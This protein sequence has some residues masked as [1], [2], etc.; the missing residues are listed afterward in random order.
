MGVSVHLMAPARWAPHSLKQAVPIAAVRLTVASED[1]AYEWDLCA[2]P[3]LLIRNESVP[4]ALKP[5]AAPDEPWPVAKWPVPLVPPAARALPVGGRVRSLVVAHPQKPSVRAYKGLFKAVGPLFGPL[6]CAH[7][8]QF[9]FVQTADLTVLKSTDLPGA[10]AAG[11]AAISAIADAT[12]E[13]LSASAAAFNDVKDDSKSSAA[14][15]R[16]RA[17]AERKDETDEK[18][19]G[20]RVTAA[21]L[22]QLRAMTAML[23]RVSPAHRSK[24][25]SRVSQRR[26]QR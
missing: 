3:S 10:Q 6:F 9:V 21:D 18:Y 13:V 17:A 19:G 1:P 15:V 25:R 8:V 20:S 7:V 26:S 16:A 4:L 2:V 24:R 12:R 11:A 22:A 14:R 23:S 5:T